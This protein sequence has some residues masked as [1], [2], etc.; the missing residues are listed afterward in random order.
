MTATTV[1]SVHVAIVFAICTTACFVWSAIASFLYCVVAA[2]FHIAQAKAM[3]HA[4][5]IQWL[6]KLPDI[7]ANWFMTMAMATTGIIG[8]LPPLAFFLLYR[9][10]A[11][12][13]R[14]PRSLFGNAKL[15]TREVMR[16]RGIR[17]D[18]NLL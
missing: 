14:R 10:I 15:A 5:Y 18:K 2:H 9:K 17:T 12:P 1:K 4:P 16:Q 8:T 7:G 6:E 3:F 13:S 11:H